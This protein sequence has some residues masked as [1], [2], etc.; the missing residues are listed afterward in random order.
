MGPGAHAASVAH[1]K[2]TREALE[3]AKAGAVEHTAA[4]AAMTAALKN[5]DALKETVASRLPIKG[6]TI[7]APH[8]GQPVD[9]CREE[10][11]A[12]VPFSSWNDTSKLLFCLR[13]AVLTHG[14]CGL[15]C[16]DS[17][18]AVDP[19]TRP[20]LEET[21]RKYAEKEGMQFLLGEATG[22]PLRITELE[23]A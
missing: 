19:K 22:G 21:C 9:I 20:A 13:V 7:A 12:L 11:G 5:L 4:S 10:K 2:G 14:E 23:A 8:P 15:V 6:M 3:R 16:I 1:A 18:D 17:I